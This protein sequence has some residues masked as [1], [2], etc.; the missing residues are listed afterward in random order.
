MRTTNAVQPIRVGFVGTG[1]IA[2]WHAKALGTI[3]A[4][5]LS[6]VC[7]KDESRARTF[8]R[9]YGVERCYES[10]DAMLGDAEL[11]LDVVHVLLPP[12]IHA[13]AAST[14]IEHGLHVFIEKPMA[15]TAR[16]CADLIEQSTIHNVMVGVNHNFLF[17][18]VYENLRNDLRAGKL[19]QADH[20][21]ITW[22]RSLE[23]LHSGP[24]NLWM[25]RDPRNIV[26]EIGAHC[27]ASMLDLVGPLEVAEVRASN[28][29]TLPGGQT[30][31]RRWGVEFGVGPVAATLHMSFS[32]GFTEQTIHVRG[33]LASATVDFERNTYLLHQHT[34]YGLDFDRYRMISRE[35]ASLRSQARRSLREYGL[36]KLKLSNRGS[37][38][39]LSIAQ[40][41][42]VV[43]C[44]VE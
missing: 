24:F 28:P 27:L 36:S 4:V 33:S 1:Y 40:S 9:R 30:F 25:L 39:G 31:Y 35:A 22:N 32:P 19:G 7:D 5:S 12:D 2:D 10:L 17:A 23:Q 13:R 21:V 6:A 38:Y 15:T 29:M 14:S 8:G 42:A 18:P 3:P 26:L 37:P 41:R 11:G 16:E 44:G 34:R 20:V 43:L